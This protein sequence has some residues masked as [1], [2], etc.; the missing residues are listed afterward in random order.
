MLWIKLFQYLSTAEKL[1]DWR[2]NALAVRRIGPTKDTDV[3][4]QLYLS[5][6]T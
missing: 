6:L 4:H 3:A 1:P 2:F 5:R